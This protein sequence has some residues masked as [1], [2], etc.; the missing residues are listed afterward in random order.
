MNEEI[1]LILISSGCSFLIALVLYILKYH[2]DK[3]KEKKKVVEKYQTEEVSLIKEVAKT[4]GL[5]I[6]I[7][8]DVL[9]MKEDLKEFKRDTKEEIKELDHRVTKVEEK[10]KM[11]SVAYK[12]NIPHDETNTLKLVRVLIVDDL[13]EGRDFMYDYFHGFAEGKWGVYKGCCLEAYCFLI[14]YYFTTLTN[15]CFSK[16]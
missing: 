1:M 9:E 12:R 6:E 5:A 11:Y 13:P 10:Q 14:E 3:I 8:N 2:A 15:N 4:N 7:K 16:R